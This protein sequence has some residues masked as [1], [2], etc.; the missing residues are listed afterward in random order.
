MSTHRNITVAFTEVQLKAIADVLDTFE[1]IA[2]TFDD[3]IQLEIKHGA[4][5]FDKSINKAGYFRE[6]GE[7]FKL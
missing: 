1:A 3:V 6:D 7:I 2:G 5:A 4:K